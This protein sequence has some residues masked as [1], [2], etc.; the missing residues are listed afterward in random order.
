LKSINDSDI[1]N[2]AIALTAGN[3]FGFQINYNSPSANG[4]PIYNGNMSQTFWKTF[5]VDPGLKSYNY[6]YDGLTD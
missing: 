4:N 5:N 1:A 3:L 2:N 6:T